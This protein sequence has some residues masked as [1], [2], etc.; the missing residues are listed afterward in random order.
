MQT[1]QHTLT[2]SDIII[3]KGEVEKFSSAL[4]ITGA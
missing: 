2:H 4:S 1:P 3:K